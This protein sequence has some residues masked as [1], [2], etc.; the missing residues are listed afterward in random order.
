M[1]FGVAASMCST[2]ELK[3]HGLSDAAVSCGIYSSLVS[4]QF[5]DL[6]TWLCAQEMRTRVSL[7]P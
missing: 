4:Q 6:V 2:N 1:E 7:I 3:R 5:G